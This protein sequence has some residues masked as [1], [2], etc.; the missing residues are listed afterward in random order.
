MKV[1]LSKPSPELKKLSY[2]VGTWLTQ[3]TIAPG[4]WGAGGKFRWAESTKWMTGGFFLVGHWNFIMPADMGGDGEELFVIGLDTRNGVYTFDAFSSQGLHQ[5][6]KGTCVGDTWTWTSDGLQ[7][8]RPVEQ[9]MTMRILSGTSYLL[10]FEISFDSKTWMTFMEGKAR[11]QKA[12][13]Q[14]RSAK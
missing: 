14:R 2:F 13:A 8:G 5:I 10:K 9:K 6:S 12:R 7:D 11:K 3:G 4:P 1:N